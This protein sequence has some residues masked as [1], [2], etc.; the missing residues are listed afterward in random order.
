VEE[1]RDAYQLTPG[2][3]A[4][5]LGGIDSRK[6]LE[7]LLQSV[8]RVQDKDPDFRLLVAGAGADINY[9]LGAKGDGVSLEY[10]GRLE[11]EEK[12]LALKACDFIVAP[13]WVGLIATDA[14]AAGR[15]I[16]TTHHYSHAPEFAYLEDNRH[17]VTSEHDPSAYASLILNL[18]HRPEHLKELQQ[19]CAYR[20]HDYS[21][22][23]MGKH[24]VA[25]I[26]QWSHQD[27]K[28]D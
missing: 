26:L 6:G 16:A 5:F 21:I 11:G 13:E 18:I 23:S 20:G 17:R 28:R 25:G 14:L 22:E 3:T 10:L 27:L 1:V 12:A 24:F 9:V 2:K 7:F 8:K 19:R 4:L 15:P